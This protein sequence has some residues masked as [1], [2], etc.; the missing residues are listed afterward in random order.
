MSTDLILKYVLLA[1]FV[2]FGLFYFMRA[3]SNTPADAAAEATEEAYARQEVLQEETEL[4][5][6]EDLAL[7]AVISA[8][9]AAYLGQETTGIK[10]SSIHRL[11]HLENGWA[12]AARQETI[13]SRQ[14][15]YNL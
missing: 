10:I 11:V 6:A 5:A 7:I 9:L 12:A 13:A 3:K 15:I 2:L 1:G 14:N 4:G 8:A